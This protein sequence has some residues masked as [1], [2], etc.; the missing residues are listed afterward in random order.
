LDDFE[1]SLLKDLG[2]TH[3]TLV[4]TATEMNNKIFSIADVLYQ[5]NV[6]LE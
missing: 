3:F 5:F 6:A 1:V 2:Y 4:K